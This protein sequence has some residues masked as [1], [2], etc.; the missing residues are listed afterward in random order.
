MS[1]YDATVDWRRCFINNK[2]AAEKEIEQSLLQSVKEWRSKMLIV[3]ET[4]KTFNNLVSKY[5]QLMHNYSIVQMCLRL[6]STVTELKE[7]LPNVPVKIEEWKKA[8]R[9]QPKSWYLN[10][11]KKSFIEI[12]YTEAITKILLAVYC[13]LN[14]KDEDDSQF[15]AILKLINDSK[16]KIVVEPEF[17]PLDL[18]P[19]TTDLS[20]NLLLLPQRKWSPLA[21]VK[22]YGLKVEPITVCSSCQ[23]IEYMSLNDDCKCNN[24]TLELTVRKLFKLGDNPFITF[25]RTHLMTVLELA[26]IMNRK[27]KWDYI[28]CSD[29]NA[30]IKVTSE[31]DV[32]CEWHLPVAGETSYSRKRTR[33]ILNISTRKVETSEFKK[34]SSLFD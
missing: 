32:V 30:F 25:D 9:V 18:T 24:P 7:V 17:S 2:I 27:F 11:L 4:V 15:E 12:G 8:I 33:V 3:D 34:F 29:R 14:I 31:S 20:A 13:H 26:I 28:A 23:D 5:G 6:V 1:D 10:M 22:A 16:P 21:L 19:F